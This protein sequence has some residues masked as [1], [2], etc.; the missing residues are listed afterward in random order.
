MCAF[1]SSDSC[2]IVMASTPSRGGAAGGSGGHTPLHGGG[3]HK[4]LVQ[5]M[6]IVH[7]DLI[8]LA[9]GRPLEESS[10]NEL[11]WQQIL[12]YYEAKTATMKVESLNAETTFTQQRYPNEPVIGS[13]I[14]TECALPSRVVSYV[15]LCQGLYTFPSALGMVSHAT[16][17][18]SDDNQ[19]DDTTREVYLEN[20]IITFIP[21]IE[22]SSVSVSNAENKKNALQIVA[23][24]E[25]ARDHPNS[26]NNG[27][28]RA[29]PSA[30]RAAV[31]QCHQLFCILR[32]GGIHQHL[33]SYQSPDSTTDKPLSDSNI[34]V[35][36]GMADVLHWLAHP[37]D[38]QYWNNETNHKPSTPYRRLIDRMN[39]IWEELPISSLRRDLRVHYDAFVGELEQR[40]SIHNVAL[41]NIIERIPAP[42]PKPD[43][44]HLRSSVPVVIDDLEQQQESFMDALSVFFLETT[45]PPSSSGT[46]EEQRKT[47]ILRGLSVFWDG[48]LVSTFAC[49][50][51]LSPVVSDTSARLLLG[52]MSAFRYRLVQSSTIQQ[53]SS[54]GSK[55]RSNSSSPS[56]PTTGLPQLV[57]SLGS[58]LE[59]KPEMKISFVDDG[60][61]PIQ[62]YASFLPP[63]PLSFLSALDDIIALEGP[64]TSTSS[65]VWGLPVTFPTSMPNES[66]NLLAVMYYH[67]N[68]DLLFYLSPPTP[69]ETTKGDDTPDFSYAQSLFKNFV[70]VADQVLAPKID[71]TTLWQRLE[72]LQFHRFHWKDP[73]I[74]IVFIDGNNGSL[75]LYSDEC[76]PSSHSKLVLKERIKPGPRGI[77]ADVNKSSRSQL[78]GSEYVAAVDSLTTALGLDCRYMLAS[79]LSVDT[80][81]ALDEAIDQVRRQK[82]GGRYESCSF[83]AQHWMY[84]HTDGN[85]GEVYILLDASKY[86][87]L[88]DVQTISREIRDE[89]FHSY[90]RIAKGSGE[91]EII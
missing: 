48:T 54:H 18:A 64:S 28:L 43:G 25:T 15:A 46:A 83:L 89:L 38:E 59:D 91:K 7:W 61:T 88:T 57:F 41:R 62:Q 76:I 87:T 24:V 17:N 79:H 26:A 37:E 21:L 71:T 45:A 11:W 31:S 53:S 44:S 6:A 14:H 30:T 5:R 3:S 51:S 70:T 80:I 39:V 82:K 78:P 2:G 56:R 50:D 65:R 34:P 47:S 12:Y 29:T 9:T 13:T 69:P 60:L 40:A 22:P 42:I 23:L 86:V 4:G 10:S 33:R 27:A 81:L 20:S 66:A 75:T 84:C 85:G 52:Y 19:N 90:E 58:R 49:K 73:G 1:L 16:E 72:P 8:E 36:Q 77:L 32:G 67:G 68:F 55:G 63:P 35:Y 74:E